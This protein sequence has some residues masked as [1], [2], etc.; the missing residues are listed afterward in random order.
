[1]GLASPEEL[2]KEDI[3]AKEKIVNITVIWNAKYIHRLRSDSALSRYDGR[4]AADG[5]A[6]RRP[7]R[8][9][10]CHVRRADDPGG[11]R[12]LALSPLDLWRLNTV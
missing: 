7:G 3:E 2:S 9:N 11:E 1:M 12:L 4:G 6:A 8:R 5:G 10:S